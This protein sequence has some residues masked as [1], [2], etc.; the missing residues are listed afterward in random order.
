MQISIESLDLLSIGGSIRRPNVPLA[1]GM[2]AR[3]AERKADIGC[4]R[5]R[6]V[7]LGQSSRRCDIDI[8]QIHPR[9]E[10]TVVRQLS[11]LQTRMEFEVSAGVASP[12]T[13]SAQ[14]ELLQGKLQGR[15]Q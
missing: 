12:Q 10:W 13:S 3:S 15:A 14:R 2:S 6:V 4:A 9:R 1:A 5:N 11:V 7:Q 8:V